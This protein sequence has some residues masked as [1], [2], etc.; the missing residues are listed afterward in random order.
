MAS[1]VKLL[2]F[3]SKGRIVFDDRG[4]VAGLLAKLEGQRLE[5]TIQ[6]HVP[7]RTLAQ[8][9]KI[10]AVYRDGLLGMEEYSGHSATEI[11]EFLKQEFCPPTITV[12][13]GKAVSRRSTTLLSVA[14]ASV[15]IERCMAW[16]A[17]H[18]VDVSGA[19]MEVS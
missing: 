18:G 19:G 5:V 14:Q 16:F 11:H 8:N 9:R 4:R 3:A 10:W 17:Q 1:P 7:G 6:K 15:Y 2:G 13:F 12:V